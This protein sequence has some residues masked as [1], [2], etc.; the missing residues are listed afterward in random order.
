MGKAK[1]ANQFLYL[2]IL[3]IHLLEIV[4][5]T[6][7]FLKLYYLLQLHANKLSE[8]WDIFTQPHNSFIKLFLEWA[9]SEYQEC[10]V[11]SLVETA[12]PTAWLVPL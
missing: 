1:V 10:E 12:P 4:F 5:Y 8:F 7:Y 9:F 11:N 6:T 3:Y 2:N